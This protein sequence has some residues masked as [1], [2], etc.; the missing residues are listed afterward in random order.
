MSR[1]HFRHDSPEPPAPA[2]SDSIRPEVAPFECFADEIAIDFPSVGPVVER[3]R[4]S[5]LGGEAAEWSD[6]LSAEV[7]LSAR[8]AREGLVVP[9]EVPI[10]GTCTCCGGRGETW[11]EPCDPCAGTGAAVFHHPVRVALPA[12][13]TDGARFRFLISS[14]HAAPVRVELR[15]EIHSAA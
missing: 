2:G 15:V 4:E 12:G 7:R 11:T 9:L 10:R 1:D 6:R 5:L 3:M 8:E 14:P 13:V